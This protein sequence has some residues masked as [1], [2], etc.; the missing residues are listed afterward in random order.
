MYNLGHDGHEKY[1]YYSD[2]S[3]WD[4]MKGTCPIYKKKVMVSSKEH[5]ID[6]TGTRKSTCYQCGNDKMI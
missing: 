3:I 1:T 4:I 5:E 6:R 2:C